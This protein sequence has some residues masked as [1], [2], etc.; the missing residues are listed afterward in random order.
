MTAAEP[1]VS[2]ARA[3]GYP[4]ILADALYRQAEV[5]LAMGRLTEA[6]VNFDEAIW[7]A[8]AARYD[9][10]VAMASIDQIYVAGALASD[11]PRGRRWFRQAEAFLARMEGHELLRSW[12]DNNFG[13]ALESHGELEAAAARYLKA[14]EVKERILGKSH[15]DVAFSLTNLASVLTE[16]GRPEEALALS[17]RGVQIMEQALG[18]EHPDTATQWANRAEILNQLGRHA[19]ARRDAERALPVWEKELG[20]KNANLVFFLGPLGEARLALG[21][22]AAAAT[23]L[24]RALA[25]AEQHAVRSEIRKLR[26]VLARALW[27]SG[28]DRP[29]AIR[30]GVLA[31]SPAPTRDDAAG[32]RALS[33]KDTDLQ[34]RAADWVVARQSESA[35]LSP[36]ARRFR[37]SSL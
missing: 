19:E 5:Q 12:M 15:P 22:P 11:M 3:T 35:S 7:T 23:L 18:P 28:Q 17:D 20:P 34:R 24:E 36:I 16:L 29:R 6:D 13:A 4:P 37:G 31:A 9:E 26:F 33:A 8:E 1:L 27:Q 32:G 2:A 30:M 14:M 21:E 10:V 25:L